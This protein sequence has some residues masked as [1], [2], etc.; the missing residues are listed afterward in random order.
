WKAGRCGL[1]PPTWTTLAELSGYGSV[2]EVMAEQRE[3]AKVV[4]KVIRD[5]DVLRLVNDR[6]RRP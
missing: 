6:L 1:L 4:P 5:G 2:A 3:V